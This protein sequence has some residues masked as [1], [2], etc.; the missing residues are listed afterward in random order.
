MFGF[1]KNKL[2]EWVGKAKEKLAEAPEEKVVEEKSKK[3]KR[4][5][6]LEKEIKKTEK[7]I[8]EVKSTSKKKKNIILE[9]EPKLSREIGKA[10]AIETEIE[11]GVPTEQIE[12]DIEK[13]E[14]PTKKSFFSRLK[15]SFSYK[16]TENNFNSIFDDLEML[17]L[18]NN[19]ALEVV[20]DIKKKLSQKLI[21]K[22]IR[23]SDLEKEIKSELKNTLNEIIIDPDNPIDAIKLKKA[24]GKPFVILFFGING[25]GKCLAGETKIQLSSG[26][27][28]EIKNVYE[29]YSQKMQEQVLEDGKII[30]LNE[31]LLIPSFNPKTLKI[32]NKKV[33]HLWKLKKEELYEIKLDNGND[34]SI[35]VTPEHPFF[36]LRNGQVIKVRAD[37]LTE[38]DYISIPKQIGIEGKLQSLFEDIKKFDI[39]I[40]LTP[41]ETKEYL[42]YK[43]KTLKDICKNLKSKR[44]YC[45]L[46]M[47]IKNGKIPLELFNKQSPNILKIKEKMSKK[48]ITFPTNLTIE[49]AEFLG[50]VMGDGHLEKDYI[51]IVNEDSEIISRIN[52]LAKLLFN[53]TPHIKKDIRTKNMYDLRLCSGTL[54]SLMSIFG[55]KSGKKG[56]Q[57]RIPKQI[58]LS[59]DETIKIFIKSYFDCDG[60]PAKK[61]RSIELTSE[62]KILITQMNMLLK[63]LGIVT[64]ISKKSINDIYYWRLTIN[65]KYAEKYAEKIGSIIKHKKERLKEYSLIGLRQGCG[66]QDMIPLGKSLKKLRLLLGFAIA[67]IQKKV[68]GYQIYEKKGIISK[69]RLNLLVEY[70]KIKHKG[71]FFELLESLNKGEI[72]KFPPYFINGMLT[73]LKKENFIQ[74]EGYEKNKIQLTENGKQYL[75]LINESSEISSLMI[76]EFE[77][78]ANS[79]VCWISLAN[80]KKI[81]NEERYV[82]DLTVEDNHSFIAEGFI[83]HNTTSIAKLTNL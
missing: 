35:K 59:D 67:D 80:S 24:S 68:P 50:Y 15:E 47:N 44:N 49:L 25:T 8:K 38:E 16:I 77:Y 26:E 4:I 73:Q 70:Y 10:I 9:E 81:K 82:Y 33:T 64:T 21:G 53:I 56:K 83:V 58:M 7:E 1:L 6:R 43:D 37:E 40:Y 66:K 34:F 42:D 36:V 63:R 46:S 17:L 61:A 71:S 23:K 76:K 14:K 72:E 41:E 27:I 69:D 28:N 51:Q 30:E 29:T 11:E 78:I 48:I 57:L 45:S 62:S 12:E 75:Q 18:E 65:S 5:K 55:L 19:V 13:I 52:D 54:V 2:K 74:N 79:N 32:E 31:D 60:S 22:E 3:D 20:E 39:D